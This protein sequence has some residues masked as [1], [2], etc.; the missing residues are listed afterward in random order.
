MSVSSYQGDVK[1]EPL[2]GHINTTENV[3]PIQAAV[4]EV[5]EESSNLF[6]LRGSKWE[7][8]LLR[9]PNPENIFHIRVEIKPDA[10][11]D[12]SGGVRSRLI[13]EYRKN[14]RALRGC[15]EILDLA[16]ESINRLQN[17]EVYPRFAVHTTRTLKKLC[18]NSQCSVSS[19]L[20]SVVSL[21]LFVLQRKED[22]G[23]ITYLP[24]DSDGQSPTGFAGTSRLTR[25][26]KVWHSFWKDGLPGGEHWAVMWGAGEHLPLHIA[27]HKDP[28]K[29]GATQVWKPLLMHGEKWESWLKDH[30]KYQHKNLNDKCIS[31]ETEAAYQFMPSNGG[32]VNRL[33]GGQGGGYS[34]SRGDGGFGLSL[35]D[36]A[37]FA[38]RWPPAKF[39]AGFSVSLPRRRHLPL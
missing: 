22:S 26:I 1:V 4:R 10:S 2:R 6:D 33:R 32:G 19:L 39:A 31:P 25:D 29:L 7:R 13:E 14:R 8:L 27:A 17:T 3:K 23:L 21:P 24:C 34:S 18:S 30:D 5:Y 16:V 12:E 11:K 35:A 20:E 36:A 38:R 9:A 28:E 15:P 37:G